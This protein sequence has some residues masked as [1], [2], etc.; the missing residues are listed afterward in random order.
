MNKFNLTVGNAKMVDINLGKK[1]NVELLSGPKELI[2][3]GGTTIM[4]E[5]RYIMH[6]AKK[7]KRGLEEDMVIHDFIAR[8]YYL[9]DAARIIL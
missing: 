4:G 2:I 8:G 5:F 3:H 7:P 9:V 6:T 1:V